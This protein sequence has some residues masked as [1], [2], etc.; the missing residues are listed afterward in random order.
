MNYWEV[1]EA[2]I[3][4]SLTTVE[5]VKVELGI[6]DTVY[7]IF[8]QQLIDE[9]SNMIVSFLGRELALTTYKELVAGSNSPFL[10]LTHYP[11]VGVEYVKLQDKEIPSTEYSVLREQGMLLRKGSWGKVYILQRGFTSPVPLEAELI[12]EVK[13]T[14]GYILPGQN[15]I[16]K[17][18]PEAIERACKDIVKILFLGRERDP[19]VASERLGD[20]SANYS[21]RVQEILQKLQTFRRVV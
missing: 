11:I 18:L 10:L 15:G 14:A 17:R 12:Y 6:E 2:P 4:R 5:D 16:G 21:D 3:T 7:D 9:A 1:V 19:S 20:Y 8:L 13:Y